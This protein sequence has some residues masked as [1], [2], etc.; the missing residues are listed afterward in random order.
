ME[1]NATDEERIAA[2]VAFFSQQGF[3][4]A[5]RQRVQCG[6]VQGHFVKLQHKNQS[7]SVLVRFAL[8]HTNVYRALASFT[9]G[10]E[11]QEEI[12]RFV[13]SFQVRK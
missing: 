3:E 6:D 9:S 8:A 13:E 1:L 12:R 4:L 11:T 5:E 10:R 2:M 7:A